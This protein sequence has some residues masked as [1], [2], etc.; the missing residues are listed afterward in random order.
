MAMKVK[1]D[2]IRT[3][4]YDYV[5]AADENIFLPIK[6]RPGEVIIVHSVCLYNPTQANFTL[7]YKVMR[8]K[9][10]LRR[11]NHTATLNAG[12]VLRWGLDNYLIDG[13]EGGFAITPAAAGDEIE[14]TFQIIRMRDDEYFKAT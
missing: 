6:A 2:Q 5:M 14:A 13:E 11:L 1:S 7:A 10:R 9:G 3:E 4:F 12:V 8:T